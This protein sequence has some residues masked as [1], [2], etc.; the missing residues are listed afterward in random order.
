MILLFLKIT[1]KTEVKANLL[2]QF[3]NFFTLLIDFY[4]FNAI[5]VSDLYWYKENLDIVPNPD[6]ESCLQKASF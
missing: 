5:S 2:H 1:V 4:S 6:P 3:G